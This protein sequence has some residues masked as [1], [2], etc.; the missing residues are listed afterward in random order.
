MPLRD[1]KYKYN[2]WVLKVYGCGENKK[3]KLVRMNVLRTAGIEDEDEK[4]AKGSAH[5][6]KM[7]ES[8]HRTKSKIF[9]LAY[10][11][12]WTWFFTATLDKTKYDRA[13]LAKWHRDLTQWFRNYNKKHNTDIK[14]LLIPELHSD[15]KSWHMHGFLYG[16]PEQHLHRFVI[17]DKMGRALADKVKK[18]DAVYKWQPYEDKFGFCDLEPIKNAE[19]VSKYVTKYITKSLSHSV[20]EVNAHM[21]Y[22]S[23]GLRFAETIKRGSMEIAVPIE[24]VTETFSND[25][26]DVYWLGYSEELLQEL[27]DSFVK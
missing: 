27:R 17:G 12:P 7:D 21:Y 9:E 25:Y 6:E 22:H 19:A 4:R 20:T 10:C 1:T 26:C 3:I 13:D 15:G 11:N 14:F 16:L 2:Q 23:R 8:I 24:Q 18:G 5:D